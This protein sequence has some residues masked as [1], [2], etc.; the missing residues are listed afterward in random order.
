MLTTIAKRHTQD[1]FFIQEH[2]GHDKHISLLKLSH[3][4]QL[5]TLF[6][7]SFNSESPN[8]SALDCTA[9]DASLLFGLAYCRRLQS[10]IARLPS[11]YIAPTLRLCK[12]LQLENSL[13][14]RWSA[15]SL[16]T[17]EAKAVATVCKRQ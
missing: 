2:Q 7:G 3:F 8:H 15:S 11:L 14:G 13:L 17:G 1:A 16:T 4:H 9:N 5:F 12:V 6:N 10:L